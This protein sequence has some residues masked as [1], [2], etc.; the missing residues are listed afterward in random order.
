MWC[1]DFD[2]I[3]ARAFFRAY[4]TPVF[5]Y[6]QNHAGQI[7]GLVSLPKLLWLDYALVAWFVL[8]FCFWSSPR[9]LPALRRIYGVHF[10]VF[11]V[12]GIAEL[13]LL[14][15]AHAW[16]PPYGISHDIFVIAMISVLLWRARGE[17]VEAKV[18]DD[19][20]NRAALRFL[21]SIRL[22]LVVEIVFAWLFYEAVK[23]QTARV[24]FADAESAV[25]ARINVL[26]W[27]AVAVAY[28]DLVRTLWTAREALF[29][30]W[31]SRR[32]EPTH[33]G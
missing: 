21:T 19:P 15:A 28:P 32:E 14:Y 24:W 7:G 23:G 4:E 30:Q 13:W 27:A 17:L 3:Y 18:P 12:R 2:R 9:V 26:T 31:M 22:A 29:P 8:P 1:C 33:A 5:Y 11:A 6:R 16:I 20:V 25:F 10:V